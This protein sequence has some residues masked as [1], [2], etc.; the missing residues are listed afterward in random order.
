MKPIKP[1]YKVLYINLG[2]LLVYTFFFAATSLD[3]PN[4][5]GIYVVSTFAFVLV[6]HF[7]I[8]LLAGIVLLIMKR[9][10]FGLGFL[11]SALLVLVIGFSSCYGIG[12]LMGN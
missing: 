2:V 12:N 5:T 8:A 11:L 9:K 6:I 7:F 10:D 4:N 1:F 3:D